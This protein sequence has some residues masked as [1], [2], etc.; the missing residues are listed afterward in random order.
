MWHKKY[1]KIEAYAQNTQKT[2]DILSQ[3]QLSFKVEY[4]VYVI[5]HKKKKKK[6]V[7]RIKYAE[8]YKTTPNTLEIIVVSDS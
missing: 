4:A 6:M 1:C 3:H 2:T 5:E 7:F 8:W